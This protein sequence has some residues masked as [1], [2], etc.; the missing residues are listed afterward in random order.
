MRI[1]KINE[2]VDDRRALQDLVR[3]KKGVSDTVDDRHLIPPKADL[4]KHD[5]NL[6]ERGVGKSALHIALHLAQQH[7]V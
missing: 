7:S 4:D 5:T 6:R 3:P 1:L 2:L